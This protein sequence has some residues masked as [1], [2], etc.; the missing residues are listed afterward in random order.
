M[1]R[2]ILIRMNPYAALLAL[3]IREAVNDAH[4]ESLENRKTYSR[5]NPLQTEFQ[6]LMFKIMLEKGNLNGAL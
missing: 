6:R 3:S 1:L 2:F 5:S 4:A